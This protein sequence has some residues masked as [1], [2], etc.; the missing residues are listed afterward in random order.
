MNENCGVF[1]AY[2]LE[3]RR[4]VTPY[5]IKG[6]VDLQHRGQLSA[7]ITSFLKTRKSLLK[8][9]KGNGL[10]DEV[11]ALANAGHSRK[12]IEDFQGIACIGHT[13]YATSGNTDPEL[14]QPFEYRHSM[15][16]KW[17]AL[18]FNGNLANYQ[19][20]AAR[21]RAEGYHMKHDVD[22]EIL[23]LY[24]A[25]ALQTEGQIRFSE[26]F[27]FLQ[28]QIDGACNAVFLNGSGDLVIY[29]DQHGIRPL[30][31]GIHDNI[32]FVAS[33]DSALNRFVPD[34]HDIKP[35]EML[36]VV[37]DHTKIQVDQISPQKPAH[38]Y[39]EWVYFSNVA[40]NI[41][42]I[43]VYLTRIRFGQELAKI[44]DQP[45]DDSCVVIAV[46][47]SARA[48]GKGFADALHV[49][50]SEGIARNRYAKRTFIE[51]ADR[52][53]K[54]QEK[55]FVI[56]DVIDGKRVFLIED[57]LVRATT[58]KALIAAIRAKAAPKEIH[59]RIACPPIF[60]PCFYGIDIPTS[61]EL[62]APQF[63]EPLLSGQLPPEILAAMARD[64]QVN[65]IKFLPVESLVNAIGLEANRL[66]MACI[67]G[68]Y[69][70]KAG[71]KN[72]LQQK[73]S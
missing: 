30:C 17:F 47:D 35:G 33:E 58:L 53:R 72:Y 44:E 48:S 42:G 16:S 18:C 71:E 43:P 40:S 68:Q 37:D 70:T 15:A 14:A 65:S 55:Y 29:R 25:K 61:R 62:F 27:T 59:I 67:K 10:V 46:P 4:N 60:A 12:I 51:G 2:D 56:R 50:Q 22:T 57:S 8:T 9:F 23:M 13:R 6:L 5:V 54:A 24:L 32:L 36:S 39:F 45:M 20:L 34:I 28:S 3:K 49:E 66:C 64:F 38:C 63:H 26:V 19:E 11:F 21:L 41:D 31:Y 7:G 52:E 73:D 1:A 69:P